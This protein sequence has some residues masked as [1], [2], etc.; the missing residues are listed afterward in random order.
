MKL[1]NKKKTWTLYLYFNGIRIKKLKVGENEEP[2]KNWY[3]IN[4]WFKKQIFN[5]NK[6]SIIVKPKYLMYNDDKKRRTYWGVVLET[7]IEI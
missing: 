1:F 5:N 7:G 6:V 2:T 3:I 4:V